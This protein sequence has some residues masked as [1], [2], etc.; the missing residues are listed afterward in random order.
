MEGFVERRKF[1]KDSVLGAGALVT[2][3]GFENLNASPAGSPGEPRPQEPSRKMAEVPG[4]SYEVT[5]DYTKIPVTVTLGKFLMSPTEVTQSE[6]EEVM[7]YNPSFHKG[8]DLPV[9]T[10]N[11]WEAIRYCNVL[12]LRESLDPCYNLETGFC[13]VQ[14]NGYRLPSDAEWA[15]AAGVKPSSTPHNAAP[16]PARN[17]ANLGNSDTT[18]VNLLLDEL[19]NSGTKPVGS[20]P[21]NQ[22]GL[23]D[24]VGNV[25]EWCNDYFDPLKRPQVSY[26]PAGPLRGIG[27]IIRG[28]SFISTTSEWGRDYRSSIEPEY[29]SRFTGFRV[30]RTLEPK[31]M[32]PAAHSSPDWYEPY[33]RRPAGYETS[34]GSLSSLVAGVSSVAEWEERR[35]AIEA[36]WLKLLGSMEI[37]PPPPKTRLVEIVEDQHYTAKL[38]YLQVEPDWWEKIL[39]MMPAGAITKPRPVVIVPFYDVDTSAGRDLS[40]RTFLGPTVDPYGYEAV[41]KGYIAVAIRWYGESYAEWYSEAVA[42][43]KLRHPNCTGLGKWVWDSQR[44]VDYL[45]TLP[46]VDHKRIGIIGHS[47]GGKMALYAPA[48]DRRITAVVS[49]EL[50]L[51]L[52]SSNYEDYWYFGDSIKHVGPDT[53]QHEL[54]ALI[55]PRPFMLIGGDMY[56]TAKSWY[57]IN[58]AR[59]VYKL[60]GKPLDI[61]Y[62]NHH[63][64]H[65]PTPEA[66]WRAMEWLAHYLGP[67]PA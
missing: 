52:A 7:G 37:S 59:E 24:M 19:N 38:M 53:D 2:G 62:F 47:L 48:F 33:N 20:Y 45:Y 54:V 40:G 21:A 11:W 6:F 57:Y 8:S 5:D 51:A 23:Y 3:A 4:T 28:G 31:A 64:G 42:N 16:P 13:D 35:K 67:E 17:Q 39:V 63:T 43:L 22:Y 25:W 50:G 9:E 1:L 58:A 56:D 61:G 60:Y 30:C 10:V 41:Q 49:N 26:N 44:L 46:E 36:K 27:R 18:H 14:K 65:M 12:S 29:K 32:L 66:V 15:H 34:I 55:A